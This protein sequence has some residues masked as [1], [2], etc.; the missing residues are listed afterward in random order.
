MADKF[1]PKYKFFHN[2]IGIGNRTDLDRYISVASKRYSVHTSD[3]VILGNRIY[4]LPINAIRQMNADYIFGKSMPSNA[5][6]GYKK[7]LLHILQS[8]HFM[9]EQKRLVDISN[10]LN[11][12]QRTRILSK[13]V[14][15]NMH[16]GMT[17]KEY[18][19]N[20]LRFML[21]LYSLGFYPHTL[22]DFIVEDVGEMDLNKK[23]E[24]LLTALESACKYAD[25]V[26]GLGVS[27]VEGI[28]SSLDCMYHDKNK[29]GAKND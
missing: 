18:S 2:Q 17:D 19:D 20:I 1:T 8:V 5:S 11:I 27:I 29:K 6:T 12:Y 10:D 26:F 28:M 3:A 24:D 21:V 13:W 25:H 16:D 9:S 4:Q 15:K 7:M 23:T 22:L 14:Q